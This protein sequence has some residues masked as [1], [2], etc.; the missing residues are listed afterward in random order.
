M[1]DFVLW[2][3]WS[4]QSFH[5]LFP[6]M[7]ASLTYTNVSVQCNIQPT[8]S[9]SN[10]QISVLESLHLPP[11]QVGNHLT[12]SDTRRS[13]QRREIQG[14]RESIRITEE[15]HR[16]DPATRILKR[17]ARRVHLV[18]LDLATGQVV[19]GT[20]GV[21]LSLV[22]AGH[23]GELR[24]VQ[25]VEVVVRGVAAGV[26]LGADGSAEDDEVL[27]DTYEVSAEGILSG[28]S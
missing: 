8:R 14:T 11:E 7:A 12:T 17:E 18:L 6:F 20:G 19:H 16:R 26:A 27:G 3:L 15:Q 28:L 1:H 25:D 21:S 13:P 2:Y 9:F 5:R 22:G 24:A 4:I 10:R 23:V